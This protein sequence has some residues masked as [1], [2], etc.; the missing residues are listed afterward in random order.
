MFWHTQADKNGKALREI[1]EAFNATKP[2][3]PVREEYIG[4]Y[5]ALFRKTMT[6]LAARRPPDLVVAYESMVAEYMKH[7]AVADLG[8][9]LSGEGKAFAEDI[10]PAFLESNRFGAFGGKLLSF[11]FTKSALMLYYN[12]DLLD[13]VGRKTPPATWEEFLAVS[14]LLKEKMKAAPYAFSR[15]ASTFDAMVYSFGSEVYDPVAGKSLFGGPGGGMRAL[16]LL[17]SLF[18][19]GLAREIAYNTYDDRADFG[20]GRAA[21]FIRSSTSRPYVADLV[22]GKFR[23]DMAVIPQEAAENPRTVLFGA[24]ICLFKSDSSREKAAWAFVKYFISRDVTARWA[25]KTGYLPVRKSSLETP[26]IAAFVAEHPANRRAFD[27]IPFAR[28]E[29]NVRGWQEVRPA[30]EKAIADV[31]GGRKTPEAAAKAL[32]EEADRILK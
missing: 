21:F 8:P 23:W 32:S 4:D 1:I 17:G 29:P 28:P 20:Q 3:R 5:D 6:S 26:E 9:L 30:I 2:A 27:A 24:N 14:R 15:D 10:F 19:D 11:P 12:A 25:V 31:I 16:S 22:K 7:E 18:K 13:A